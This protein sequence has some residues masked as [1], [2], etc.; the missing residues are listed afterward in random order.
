MLSSVLRTDVRF[1]SNELLEFVGFI[2]AVVATAF[3]SFNTGYEFMAFVLY[4][5]SN[6][7]WFSYALNAN[8]RWLLMQNVIF[9]VFT[10]NGLVNVWPTI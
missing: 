4:G 5:V 6:I 1:V 7:A 2:T 9:M 10:I 8:A 3:M